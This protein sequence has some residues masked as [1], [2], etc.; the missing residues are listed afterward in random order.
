M[1]FF[2]LNPQTR[3]KIFTKKWGKNFCF[4]PFLGHLLTGYRGLVAS[5]DFKV[6]DLI[7]NDKLVVSTTISPVGIYNVTKRVQDVFA[8]ILISNDKDQEEFLR[9]IR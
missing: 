6:S 3:K 7:F 1:I 2:G 4:K 9:A 5:R 8:Q